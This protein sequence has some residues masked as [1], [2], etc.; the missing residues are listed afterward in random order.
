MRSIVD[1]AV[2]EVSME[3]TL[4]ELEATWATLK[5]GKEEHANSFESFRRVDCNSGRQPSSTANI[6]HLKVRRPFG[7]GSKYCFGNDAQLFNGWMKD[8]KMR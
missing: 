2:H 5:L 1:R 7:G 6:D 8:T 4:K 3:K